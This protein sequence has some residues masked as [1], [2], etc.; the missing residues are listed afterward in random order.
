MSTEKPVCDLVG[1]VEG[2]R[3]AVIG[4]VARTLKQAGLREEAEEFTR[5]A[6]DE[7]RYEDVLRVV[8]DFVDV[9]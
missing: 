7:E 6:V 1:I 2:N 5:Q 8:K 3:Y 4:T 9:K